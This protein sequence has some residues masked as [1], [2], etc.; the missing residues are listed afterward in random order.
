M[1]QPTPNTNILAVGDFPTGMTQ[2]MPGELP[3]SEQMTFVQYGEVT[4]GLLKQLS[5]TV[6]LSPVICNSFDCI[7]LALRLIEIGYQG[8]YRVL[9]DGLAKPGMI[10]SEVRSQAPGLDFDTVDNVDTI[11]KA[12]VFAV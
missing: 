2:N 4:T 11:A 6:V 9:A 8:K 5:P 3:A 7:D 10:K 1:S 12:R